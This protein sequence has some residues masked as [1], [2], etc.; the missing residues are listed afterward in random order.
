MRKTCT[1]C[2]Q[3]PQWNHNGHGPGSGLCSDCLD[4]ATEMI[5]DVQAIIA[6]YGV[7]EAS[8]ER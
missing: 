2:H 7:T 5:L 1:H 6:F 4:I 3:A 8:D